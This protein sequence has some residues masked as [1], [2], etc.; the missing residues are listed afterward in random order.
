MVH[1]VFQQASSRSNQGS[2]LVLP[3]SECR[4]FSLTNLEARGL[5]GK[6]GLNWLESQREA[7]N[8]SKTRYGTVGPTLRLGASVFACDDVRDNVLLYFAGR[9]WH[10][11]HLHHSVHY[12]LWAI[13]NKMWL[14]AA[15]SLAICIA[16]PEP[17][18]LYLG[19]LS[20]LPPRSGG[21]W[22]V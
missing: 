19:C 9:L 16:P 11:P 10:C 18:G 15:L 17:R 7:P 2:R 8:F 5:L 13:A 3:V 14:D 22:P 20:Q 4:P 12:I 21:P 1:P 6:V